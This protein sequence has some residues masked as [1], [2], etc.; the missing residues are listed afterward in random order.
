MRIR[1]PQFRT[2]PFSFD[3]IRKTE[4][5]FVLGLRV[6]PPHSSL[7]KL[8]VLEGTHQGLGDS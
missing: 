4:A 3:V 2:D 8:S 7:L 6:R 1:G 5:E